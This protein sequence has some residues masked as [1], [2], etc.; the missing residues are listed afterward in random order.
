MT[1]ARSE[2]L[3]RLRVQGQSMTGAGILPGEIVRLRE[4]QDSAAGLIADPGALPVVDG[5]SIPMLQKRMNIGAW[6]ACGAQRSRLF[7]AF[8]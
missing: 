5:R 3:F 6:T 2:E 1:Y 8:R 4:E 7:G